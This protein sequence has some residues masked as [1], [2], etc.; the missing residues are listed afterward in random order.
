MNNLKRRGT[1][2]SYVESQQQDLY[3]SLPPT[4]NHNNGTT[5]MNHA[6]STGDL[7]DYHQQGQESSMPQTPMTQSGSEIHLIKET[8]PEE[9]RRIFR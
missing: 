8:A 5:Y 1:R 6:Y 7:L 2:L 3:T 4:F 9:K